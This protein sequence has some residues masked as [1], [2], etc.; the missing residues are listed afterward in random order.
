[1]ITTKAGRYGD[2]TVYWYGI[3]VARYSHSVS[4]WMVMLD[5]IMWERD[6]DIWEDARNQLMKKG[7][8]I[9]ETE[10]IA[11]KIVWNALMC[12]QSG[13]PFSHNGKKAKH[14]PI[15]APVKGDSEIVGLL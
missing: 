1:M 6:G 5:I 7:P 12:R 3:Q 14:P 4:G 13:T 8:C 2:I 15:I 9:V 10:A 11:H